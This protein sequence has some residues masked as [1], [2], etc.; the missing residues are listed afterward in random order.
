MG[1]PLLATLPLPQYRRRIV[2]SMP[3][4]VASSR[5]DKSEA[6][7]IG[8]GATRA[9]GLTQV[10]LGSVIRLPLPVCASRA[11]QHRYV[12]SSVAIPARRATHKMSHTCS[13]TYWLRVMCCAAGRWLPAQCLCYR[14]GCCVV[15]C[16]VRTRAGCTVL[17]SSA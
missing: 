3:Q 10:A 9:A 11:A 1:W 16:R 8:R 14:P 17:Y 7:R 5:S 15:D 4:M 13:G 2:P 12:T 6:L